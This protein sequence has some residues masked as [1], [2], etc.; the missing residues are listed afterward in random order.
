[1]CQLDLSEK[2]QADVEEVTKA[3]DEAEHC[4]QLYEQECAK[5]VTEAESE[6][7]LCQ[8][9][10]LNNENLHNIFNFNSSGLSEAELVVDSIRRTLL[11]HDLRRLRN[12]P[13][14]DTMGAEMEPDASPS[15]AEPF[16]VVDVDEAG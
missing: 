12:I 15:H 8:C 4:K 16:G 3:K 11:D 10:S 13:G 6:W 1:M 9:M 5:R 2:R 7:V 14:A